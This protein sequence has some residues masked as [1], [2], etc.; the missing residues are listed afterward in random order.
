[1]AEGLDKWIDELVAE[2][3]AHPDFP[4]TPEE[5]FAQSEKLGIPREWLDEE[6]YVKIDEFENEFVELCRK[7]F[8]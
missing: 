5:R 7:R 1:V 2:H 8:G 3:F 6:G 4:R